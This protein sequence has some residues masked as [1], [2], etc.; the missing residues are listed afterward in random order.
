[1]EANARNEAQ[2]RVQRLL[3]QNADLLQHISLLVK[4]I[5]ELEIKASGRFPSSEFSH[6]P[7]GL[8][9]T[10]TRLCSCTDAAGSSYLYLTATVAEASAA[11]SCVGQWLCASAYEPPASRISHTHA[12]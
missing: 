6:L 7:I 11:L 5:Q 1:M 2:V 4:Q 8:C 3:Q 12:A 9:L 10:S